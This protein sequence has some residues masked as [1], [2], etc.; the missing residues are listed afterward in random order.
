MKIP[1]FIMTI[2]CNII[3]KICPSYKVGRPR[4]T[5]DEYILKNIFK[6]LRT[7][8][9]WRELDT[10]HLSPKTINNYFNKWSRLN[11]FSEAYKYLIRLLYH[12]KKTIKSAYYITD[13]SFIKSIFGIDVIGKN[14]TDR[15]RNASKISVVVDDNGIPLSISLYPGNR[16]DCILLKETLNNMIVTSKK[17]KNLYADK[18]YDS[19][20]CRTILYDYGYNDFILK[21][22]ECNKIYSGIRVL[23][24]RFFSWMKL[25]RRLIVR[26]DK[27]ASNY[28]QYCYMAFSVLVYN[29][30]NV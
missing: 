17:R 5:N 13:T 3:N 25:Y 28:L 8:M 20:N 26:Y 21:R 9:Q 4:L 27:L 11:I 30:T 19:K 10:I 16:N 22:G 7:G 1:P 24:E 23:V 18:G 14:P 15:G 6:I 12:K 2:F 29:K